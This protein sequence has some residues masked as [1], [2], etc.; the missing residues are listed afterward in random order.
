[1][2]L[3]QKLTALIRLKDAALTA[4]EVPGLVRVERAG[5][6]L[7]LSVQ[8]LTPFCLTLVSTKTTTEED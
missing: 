7:T 3:S 1:M 2:T 4:A 8:G 5:E 6:T